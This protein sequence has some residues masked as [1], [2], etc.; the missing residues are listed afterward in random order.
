MKYYRR[1]KET[2]QLVLKAF[3]EGNIA[4]PLAQVFVSREHDTPSRHWSFMNQ[5]SCA[6]AGCID[7]RGF[8]QWKEAGRSVSKGEKARAFIL[9]PLFRK[10]DEDDEDKDGKYLYGFT[11]AAVFD[12]SQTDGDTIV[13]EATFLDDLPLIEVAK[14]WDIIVTLYPG[15]EGGPLG[16]YSPS[17]G[18]IALGTEN[19]STWAHEL[20]HAADEKL[21]T[22]THS[23]TGQDP[24]AEI[25][26]ELGGAV[27]L[28]MIGLKVEA[29]LGGAWDYV[30]HYGKDNPLNACS[31]L[32]DRICHCI[33]HIL[34]TSAGF[35]E[36]V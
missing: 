20:M 18:V 22:L 30:K 24:A 13:H 31:K 32:L 29:D 35:E 6:I 7:P 12:V 8:R 16:Q 11:T 28:T 2:A 15:A 26:A 1:S 34:E 21:G 4:E 17:D 33:E 14:A 3:E 25:V 23:S 19:Q 9:V 5:F 36:V 10:A 27:L